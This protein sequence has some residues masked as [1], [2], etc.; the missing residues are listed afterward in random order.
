MGNKKNQTELQPVIP[1]VTS[2]FLWGSGQFI[3]KEYIKGGILLFLQSLCIGLELCT[4]NYFLGPFSCRESGGFFVKGVWGLITL[5]TNPR[6]MTLSGLSEGDHS[7]VL[8]IQGII[9]VIVAA[10]FLLVYLYNIKDAYITAKRI[11]ET[12]ERFTAKEYGKD[13]WRR[14]FH[15]IV[16]LPAIILL[17]FL[18]VMPIIFSALAAFTN[19]TK[20]NMPPTKLVSWV[21]FKNFLNLIKIP[22]W[23]DTFLGVLGWTVIWAV[24]STVT[25]FFGGLF[26][27]VILNS[28]A[29]KLKKL[30]RGIYILPWAIPGLITLLVFRTMFNGQF[31]PVSQLLLDLGITSERVAWFTDPNRPNLA[32]ITIIIINLWMGFPYFMALMT[33]IMSGIS[34]ELYE[35]AKLDGARPRDELRYITLPLVLNAAAPLLIMNFA[36]NFNNFGTIYFL[37]GGGPTNSGYQFAGSTDILIT[38]IYKLTVDNQMYNMASVMSILI[39]LVIGA[40]S[41]WNLRRTKAFKE[42]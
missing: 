26:Q 8:M 16:L 14:S 1:A 2:F 3:N 17:L 27:A 42:D 31:G 5:G 41:I 22:I 34:E 4:G 9:A 32:R 15:Y 12:G 28:K 36:G 29:V 7:I 10:I 25:C 30:W 21:G 11:R 19:Y 20:S 39:F 38:W 33:G 35:A 18:T 23:T 24:V 40:V 37:T 13:L 6:K